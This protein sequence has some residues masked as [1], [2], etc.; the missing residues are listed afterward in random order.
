MI[1]HLSLAYIIIVLITINAAKPGI[2]KIP[3]I[4]EVIRLIGICKSKL[5][6]KVFTKNNNNAPIITLINSWPIHLKGLIGAPTNNRTSINP[7]RTEKT[8]MGSIYITHFHTM[9]IIKHMK[10]VKK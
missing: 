6:P 8:M 3:E 9:L 5:V 2:P 7:P 1:N 10:G 4:E